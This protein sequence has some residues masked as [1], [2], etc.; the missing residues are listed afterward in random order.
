MTLDECSE[1]ELPLLKYGNGR[2]T[3][4][5]ETLKDESLANCHKHSTLGVHGKMVYY[6]KKF[7]MNWMFQSF[8]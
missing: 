3:I 8:R 1:V 5:K 2:D 4:V 7:Q 6:S